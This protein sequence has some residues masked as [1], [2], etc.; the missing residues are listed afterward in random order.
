MPPAGVGKVVLPDHTH[1]LRVV[2]GALKL[3]V[4]PEPGHPVLVVTQIERTLVVATPTEGE[5]ITGTVI[6][7]LDGERQDALA[8]P[9][10]L[11]LAV[12]RAHRQGDVQ[13]ERD[14]GTV[15]GHALLPKGNPGTL[16]QVDHGRRGHGELLFQPGGLRRGHRIADAGGCRP[17]RGRPRQRP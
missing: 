12:Q 7:E 3:A 1:G 4:T 16:D 17:P 11:A 6:I 8:Q 14:P 13:A 2:G 5:H 15:L 10:H 9:L